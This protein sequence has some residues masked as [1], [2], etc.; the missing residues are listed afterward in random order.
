MPSW[1]RV[2]LEPVA[3]RD[4]Y[5]HQLS[6]GQQQ[7][8]VIAIAL[9]VQPRLL[10]LD[11]PTTGLDATVEAGV[12][13]LVRD[14]RHELSSSVLYIT[15]DLGI[16]PTVADRVAVLYAGEIV[17]QGDVA[18]VLANPEHPYTRALMDAVPT[19]GHTKRHGDLATIPGTLPAVGD[20]IVGCAF[21]ARCRFADAGCTASPI[22]LATRDAG[23]VVRC[24]RV[25]EVAASMGATDR[26][27]RPPLF[28]P[29]RESARATDHPTAP[30]AGAPPTLL[31]LTS[32]TKRFG[33]VVAVDDVS[34]HVRA[35]RGARPRRCLW[36]WQ[37]D[38][39]PARHR[40][41]R[42]RHRTGP[43]GR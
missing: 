9:A 11:E 8:V 7:R 3:I 18:T 41:D 37:V 30:A 33:E 6:G 10:V 43:P 17:E 26:P 20:E 24:R 36:Q 38:D 31:E 5:P 27:E 35:G 4:R 23:R 16:V 19:P 39:R 14:L 40:A 12:L 34:L 28:E 25:D 21:A 29:A 42:P 32:V 13:R 2:D 1:Q 22:A 15:H